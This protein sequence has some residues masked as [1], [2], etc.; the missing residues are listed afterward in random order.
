[1]HSENVEWWCKILVSS[2]IKLQSLPQNP[3]PYTR[4]LHP[5]PVHAGPNTVVVRQPL[6][7]THCSNSWAFVIHIL[8]ACLPYH[9][10]CH[11]LV[12]NT[13]LVVMLISG[14]F[15]YSFQCFLSIP[16]SIYV[17]HACFINEASF[18]LSY[19]SILKGSTNPPQSW[20]PIR[21]AGCGGYSRASGGQ[22]P[23]RQEWS[24][25]AGGAGWCEG[26][27]W[28]FPPQIQSHWCTASS[29]PIGD[30]T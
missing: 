13:L 27:S 25:P 24:H 15:K 19:H 30:C 6:T 3:I 21:G 23:H 5:K 9:I 26:Y 20:R 17:N 18:N 16:H 11:R 1:M 4:P 28:L 29:I 14:I 10:R 2:P 22:Y 7:W 8:V 12:K